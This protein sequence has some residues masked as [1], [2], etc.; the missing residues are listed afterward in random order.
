MALVNC[1]RPYINAGKGSDEAKYQKI[2]AES[3][4]GRV[5]PGESGPWE[6]DAVQY[7]QRPPRA[8]Q[9]NGVNLWDNSSWQKAQKCAKSIETYFGVTLY[10]LNDGTKWIGAEYST[11]ENFDR[12]GVFA[13][14]KERL[15]RMRGK[16]NKKWQTMDTEQTLYREILFQ[17]CCSHTTNPALQDLKRYGDRLSLPLV[18]FKHSP[19]RLSVAHR[20]HGSGMSSGWVS[21]NATDVQERI[22]NDKANNMLIESWYVNAAKQDMAEDY[23]DEL[24]NILCSA[25]ITDTAIYNPGTV[26]PA[27]P[28]VKPSIKELPVTDEFAGAQFNQADVDE[29]SKTPSAGQVST[30]IGGHGDSEAP[31]TAEGNLGG[32]QEPRTGVPEEF[33]PSLVPGADSE[34]LNQAVSGLYGTILKSEALANQLQ[35]DPAMRRMLSNLQQMADE[36]NQEGFDMCL[37]QIYEVY[38]GPAQQGDMA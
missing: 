30:P 25:K 28:S 20:V 9:A 13:F 29:D 1:K 16:C 37:G 7:V 17:Y 4:A 14:C 6:Q 26:P 2:I 12:N 32:D 23:Y 15:Q 11:P 33:E 3:I 38:V 27:T 19:L 8:Y 5:T 18:L 22:D 34:E 31:E 21:D 24:D 36:G 10:E 35:H